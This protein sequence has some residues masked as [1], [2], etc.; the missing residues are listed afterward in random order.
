VE[1]VEGEGRVIEIA[2]MI[3][4]GGAKESAALHAREILKR[5]EVQ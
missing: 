3:G 4:G 2:R 1:L 5:A